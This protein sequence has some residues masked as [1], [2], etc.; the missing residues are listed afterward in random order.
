[1][2]IFTA[3]ELEELRRADA[4]IDAEF[5]QTAEEIKQSRAR[6][7]VAK[8]LNMDPQQLGKWR[9]RHK[10]YE[11]HRDKEL[12]YQRARYAANRD[13]E[14]ERCAAYREANKEYVAEYNR[15]YREANREKLAARQRAYYAANRE[16]VKER[17]KTY[18]RK[19]KGRGKN[20]A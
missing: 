19:Q 7:K 13:K 10:Y 1:M 8:R 2:S 4:E 12:E 17:M 16:K 15:A 5:C 6:D 3:A 20:D 14:R 11:A 18:R 9:K